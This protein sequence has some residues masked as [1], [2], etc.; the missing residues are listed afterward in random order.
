V[1]NTTSQQIEAAID[2]ESFQNT[3]KNFQLIF[4]TSNTISQSDLQKLDELFQNAEFLQFFA[5]EVNS[6]IVSIY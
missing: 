3:L 2:K 5:Q 6:E 1:I 4:E